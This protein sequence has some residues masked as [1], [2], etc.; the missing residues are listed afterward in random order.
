M[1]DLEITIRNIAQKECGGEVVGLTNVSLGWSGSS[2]YV[3]EI[4]NDDDVERV[5]IKTGSSGA[6]TAFEDEPDNKRVYG[7]RFSNLEPAYRLMLK[8]KIKVPELLAKGMEGNIPYV[9]MEFLEGNTKVPE[10]MV[11][12]EMGKL[13][14]ITRD[15]Q[16]CVSMNTP[17][18]KT[19]KDAYFSAIRTQLAVAAGTSDAL[20]NIL[21]QVN[22]F[23]DE[24]EKQWQDPSHFVLSHTDGF[25]GIARKTDEVYEFMGVIDLEDH[26]FTDQ[27]FVLAG[28][29]LLSELWMS[30]KVS[31]EFW[32]IYKTH[33]QVEPSYTDFRSLFQL[34]Y[35]LDWL[36][37]YYKRSDE[38]R[39]TKYITGAE[40]LIF[41]IVSQRVG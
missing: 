26:Q 25:Q 17:Y 8:H 2:V 9:V 36:T 15:Y 3:A 32:D 23:V 30:K 10:P 27:R 34:Y 11:A 40:K 19:W 20:T 7:G 1:D 6:E 16:G 29:E 13:H 31:Q 5:V 4:K 33:T 28:H 18:P 22:R 39:M 41:D 21:S 37:S 14:S 38:P 12:D 24:K 35:L